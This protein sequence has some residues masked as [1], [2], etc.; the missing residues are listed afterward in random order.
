MII[1]NQSGIGRGLFSEKDYDLLNKK[2]LL[3]LSSNNIFI[4]GVYH[5]PHKPED[6]CLCRKPNVELFERANLDLQIDSSKSYMIGDKLS[7]IEAGMKFGCTSIL[8]RTGNGVVHSKL[9]TKM[10]VWPN[11]ICKDLH[12]AV[13][14]IKQQ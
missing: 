4:S 8:V 3:D 11:K 12:S 14:W 10:N 5:C 7:D 1:T 13:T 9:C 6:Y 2:M